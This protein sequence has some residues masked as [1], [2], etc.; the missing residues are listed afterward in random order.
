MEPFQPAEQ[1]WGD[2]PRFASV[3]QDGLHHGGIE[4]ATNSG[5]GRFLLAV[6]ALSAPSTAAP[7]ASVP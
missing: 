3:E 5:E 4:F 6:L 1:G 7:S 2:R